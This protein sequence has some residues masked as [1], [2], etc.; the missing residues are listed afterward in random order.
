[1]QRIHHHREETRGGH[2]KRVNAKML[3]WFEQHATMEMAIQR[4]KRIK[5]WNRQWRVNL[6]EGENPDWRDLALDFGFERLP[7]TV[8]N[9]NNGRVMDS[10]LRG[11]DEV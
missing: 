2:S 9:N 6:I 8:V 5:N 4:E 11:N 3:V 10:R 1:M 7:T